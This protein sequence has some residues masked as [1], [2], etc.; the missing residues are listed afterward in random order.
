MLSGQRRKNSSSR[1]SWYVNRIIGICILARYEIHTVTMS[2]RPLVL[3]SIQS[4]LHE[5]YPVR[6]LQFGTGNFLRGFADWMFQKMNQRI[7]TDWGVAAVQTI[8]S[9]GTLSQQEGQ[10]TVIETHAS[11]QGVRYQYDRVQVVQNVL[12]AQRDWPALVALAC[13]P[14]LRV[15]LSNTTENG[16][17]F[18]TEPL[19]T[20]T[21]A[22]TYPGKL[23]QLLWA[24]FQAAAEPMIILPCEL[25]EQN[26]DTLKNCVLQYARA[27]HLPQE[28]L[29]YVQRQAFCNTLVDRIVPGF[30]ANPEYHWEALGYRDELLTLC[31]SYSL[32]VIQG[33]AWVQQELPFPQ[34]RLNVI[35]TQDI[36]PYR[37]RKVRILN[38]AHSIMAPMG[39][40]AEIKTVREFM[41]HPVLGPF[42]KQTVS[43]DIVPFLPGDPAEL[44]RYQQ[45][46]LARFL[47]P[48]IRHEFNSIILNSLSKYRVRILPALEAYY[49]LHHRL[50]DRL[51]MAFASLFLVYARAEASHPV[52]DQPEWLA[53]FK[54]RWSK[55]TTGERGL[56]KLVNELL[57][58]EEWWGKDLR[59]YPE[60]AERIASFFSRIEKQGVVPVIAEI[61]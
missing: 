51:V 4:I 46:V 12:H 37:I 9:S 14:A 40:L 7:R 29:V 15:I 42:I 30:P 44:H 10:F 23:C 52:N 55:R 22:R 53:E 39:L 34:A 19:L 21:P 33:P 24:R 48:A 27:W 41:E 31:E 25:I 6:V 20:H 26:G 54:L 32:W 36:E 58:H 3:P 49:R 50:P 61:R 16:I 13:T 28:F 57:A 1:Q 5:P 59:T 35:Y 8:G 38:G 47:N 56:M 2:V 17:A 60:L 43:D 11:P 18:E 45:D